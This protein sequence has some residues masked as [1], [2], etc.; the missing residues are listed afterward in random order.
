MRARVIVTED[1]APEPLDWLRS[2]CLV[3][4]APVDSRA[5]AAL[6]PNAEALVV[7]TYTRVNES[8]LANLPALRVVGRAGTGLDSIDLGACRARGVRVVHTPDANTRAVVE[9]VLAALLR[10]E[11]P[12]VPLS[13]ALSL[14]AWNEARRRAIAPRELAG[15]TLGIL[16]LGR[17][18]R[19]VARAAGALNMTVIYHDLRTIDPPHRF[20]A[21]P[22]GLDDLLARSDVLSVHVDERASNRD[23]LGAPA[24]AAMKPGAV[25]INTSRGFV[26][27]EQA[28]ASHLHHHP[29]ARAILDVFE[30]E[31]PPASSALF[32]LANATLTPHIA[33]ATARAKEAMSWVVR[34]VWRVLEGESPEF[35][36]AA[37]GPG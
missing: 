26:V 11:R 30:P 16:G 29:Q 27:S 18:G 28:L 3:E 23:L 6:A 34:D 32:G 36:A 22:V 14:P 13:Q 1:L 7:R 24:F 15:Q 9:F 2:R 33:S 20:G 35:E 12:V 5:F 8:L 37:P 10:L 17:I 21:A 19:Q 25:F 31:P 4:F